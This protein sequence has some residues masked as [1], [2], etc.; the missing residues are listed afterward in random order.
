MKAGLLLFFLSIATPVFAGEIETVLMVSIDALHP[1]ALS[2]KTSPALERL[3]R[4]GRYTLEGRSVTP[5]QTLI[6]HTAM[7]T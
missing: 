4:S 3:M 7:M 5:P 2:Q 1:A 6:A